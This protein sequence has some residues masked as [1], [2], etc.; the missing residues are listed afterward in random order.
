MDGEFPVTAAR[1]PRTAPTVFED[2]FELAP[3]SL[4]LEDYSEVR[5][6]FE[7]WRAEGVDQPARASRAPARPGRGVFVPHP[8]AE[9][10]PAHAGA[11]RRRQPRAPRRPSAAGVSRRHVRPARRGAGRVVGRPQSLCQHHGQLHAVGGDASTS[12]CTRR[13]LPGFEDT[14]RRVLL[15]IEDITENARTHRNLV[16][17]E[18]YARGLFEHSPVSLW[19]EDFSAVKARLDEVRALAI[20]DFR[21]FIDV[22]PE[23]VTRCLRE[24]RVMDVNQQTLKMFAAPDKESLVTRLDEV[25]RDAHAHAFRGATRRPVGGQALPAARSRQLF[26]GRRCRRCAPAVL[27][28]ARFTRQRGSSCSFRSPTSRHEKRPRPISSSSAST[29]C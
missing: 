13:S 20:T 2:M 25:F 16:R 23:F 24:I 8:R 26:A 10:Q 17:S 14:W 22:H 7:R 11:L 27:R 1:G 15:A 29:T 5:E 6:L 9:S 21:V 12:C 28:P 3:V 19:V 18:H 4:W